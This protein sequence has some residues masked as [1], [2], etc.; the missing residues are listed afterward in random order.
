VTLGRNLVYSALSQVW[1]LAVVFITVPIVVRAL[2]TQAYGIYVLATLLLGY[3]A[4]LDLGLTPSVVRSIAARHIE[5][6]VPALQ[7]LIGTAL[8]LLLG[9]GL[10]GGAIIALLTPNLSH[11]WLHIPARLQA[12]AQF[13]LYLAAAGFVLNMCL[14]VFGAVPQGLQRLDLFALRSLAL[15]TVTGVAQITVVVLG[16]GLRWLAAVTVLINVLSLAVFVLVAK[17]LIP[18]L[19]LLPQFNRWAA[20]ELL[21]FGALRF[22][23]QLA[24]QVVFQLDRLIVAAFLTIAAVTFYS[25]PL[26]IAQRFV[27]VQAI[28][29]TA[30]FPAATELHALADRRRLQ[31]AYLTSM[32][33]V[34]VM[35]VPMVILVAGFS[36][37]LLDGWLGPSFADASA[38][39]L[40]VLAI[41]YGLA[42][43]M[44][45]PTLAADATGHVHWSAGFAIVSAVINLT[46]TIVLVPRVGAIG[47]AYALLINA[48]TQGLVFVYVVQRR[49]VRVS[50]R[51]MLE[52]AAIRPITA[53]LVLLGYVALL[54]PRLHG[55]IT[56]LLAMAVGGAIY[57]GLTVALRVWDPREIALARSLLNIRSWRPRAAVASGDPDLPT[58]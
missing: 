16:G 52:R 49:F 56:V 55:L 5:G 23:N 30:F 39:I 54:A 12:D 25:V 8:T 1:S 38:G 50:L 22:V 42:Q 34:L 33:L 9:L 35:V 19:S 44:G 51:T 17:R 28:F 27:I 24:G 32:K 14:T 6:D 45:V 37:P 4:F 18:G 57:F 3:T 29:A 47:A 40:A 41:A 48:A 13:V 20:R 58:Q 11:H 36:H 26:S 53:G 7:G 43:V 46:L 2:G 21:S 31:A 15:T 10:V